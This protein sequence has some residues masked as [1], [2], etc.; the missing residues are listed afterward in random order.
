[1][2]W[3]WCN[4]QRGTVGLGSFS[5]EKDGLLVLPVNSF[6]DRSGVVGVGVSVPSVKAAAFLR[7]RMNGFELELRY[8][9]MERPKD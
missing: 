1:M 3:L 4:V 2:Q 8:P 6:L 9:F 7:G 5:R